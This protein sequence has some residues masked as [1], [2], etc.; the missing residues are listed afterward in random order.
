MPEWWTYAPA[1][2]QLFSARTYA[3]LVEAH[4]RAL[5]PAQWLD[6]ACGAVLWLALLR[7]VSWAARALAALAAL[8][9]IGLAWDF[10]HLRYA[11]IHWG[12]PAMA[13]GFSWQAL[14][15]AVL[16][17]RNAFQPLP[18]PRA[19]A[20]AL[21]LLAL[22]LV[23]WPLLAPLTGASWWRAEV[24]GLMP[25]PTVLAMLALAPLATARARRWLL[26]L[27]L[28]WCAVEALTLAALGSA[29]WPL[30]P[31]AGLACLVAPT[32]CSA[33]RAG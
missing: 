12:A 3:R 25:A 27:P 11:Q 7:R 1:D 26:P 4:N 22:A 23:G 10:F 5:W 33:H 19:R 15:L 9:C 18:A 29:A 16:A 8:W 30:L 32:V 24:P 31:L 13:V 6:L 14:L 20:A 2:F 28:L 21:M 17:R